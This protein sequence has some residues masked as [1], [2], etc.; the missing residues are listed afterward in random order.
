MLCPYPQPLQAI[1][2]FHG[3]KALR[4]RFSEVNQGQLPRSVNFR[5]GQVGEHRTYRK[6]ERE[7]GR[8]ERKKK[9]ER[10]C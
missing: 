4:A 8:E 1:P 6:R 7:R 3:Y 2:N 5:T 9:R 10:E